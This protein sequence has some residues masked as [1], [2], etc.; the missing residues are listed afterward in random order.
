MPIVIKNSQI[1]GLIQIAQDYIVVLAIPFSHLSSGTS[2][3]MNFLMPLVA[4]FDTKLGSDSVVYEVKMR[5]GPV[6]VKKMP[7]FMLPPFVGLLTCTMVDSWSGDL[8]VMLTNAL[9]Q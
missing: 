6:P 3:A 5:I 1:I 8:N 4:S 7:A 9:T 2:Y